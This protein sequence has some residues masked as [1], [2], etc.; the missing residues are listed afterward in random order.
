MLLN[1]ESLATKLYVKNMANKFEEVAESRE[2]PKRD[3]RIFTMLN[4]EKIVDE[5]YQYVKGY[6]D[7]KSKGTDKYKGQVA[8]QTIQFYNRMFTDDKKYRRKMY[9]A[10]MKDIVKGFLEK[11]K[12]LQEIMEQYVDESA[13]DP[14]MKTLLELT[15]NQFKKVSKV[16]KDDIEIYMWLMYDG[17][18]KNHDHKY[19]LPTSLRV[20]FNTPSTPVMHLYKN[21]FGE[22][23]VK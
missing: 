4:Y 9:L 14:E 17:T 18:F 23:E 20:A 13:I 12:L 2:M 22:K 11:T 5:M 16:N 1:K 15:D 10:D 7:Y 19:D 3:V 8:G 6:V 21:E